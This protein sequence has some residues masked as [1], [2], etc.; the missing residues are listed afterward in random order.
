MNEAIEVIVKGQH[1]NGGFFYGYKTIGSSNFSN[2][3]YNFQAKKTAY[4]AGCTVEELKEGIDRA[5]A[6]IHNFAKDH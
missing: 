2:V 6:H 5:I 3:S 4:A 1:E